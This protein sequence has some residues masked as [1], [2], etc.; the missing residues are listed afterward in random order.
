MTSVD[1][2][3]LRDPVRVA[4][5]ARARRLA[6]AL[7]MPLDALAGLA[8]RLLG[9]PMGL[10]TFVGADEEHVAGAY[11]LPSP[12]PAGRYVVSA[13]GPVSAPDLGDDPLAAQ[14]GVRSYLGV[15]LRDGEHRAVGALAVLD[16]A[17]RDWTAQQQ[18]TLAEIAHLLN[19]VPVDTAPGSERVAGLDSAA[20]LDSVQEAFVAVGPDGS[21][22]AWNRA[23]EELLGWPAA[24]ICGRSLAATVLPHWGEHAVG[25]ALDRL[26]ATPAGPPLERAATVRHRDGHEVPVRLSLSL[27][28]GARGALACAFVTDRSGE[29]SA[30]GDA[31][32]ER[33]FAEALLDSLQVGVLAWDA[34]GQVVRCNRAARE[35]FGLPSGL[36]ATGFLQEAQSR[37][38]HPDGTPVAPGDFGRRA[39]SGT[40]VRDV[41]LVVGYPGTP[42]RYLSVNA[43]PLRGSDG[44]PVGAVAAVCDVT[45]QRRTERFRACEL[46]VARTLAGAADLT[47]AAPALLAAVADALGWPMTEL[48]LVDG[49][50]DSLRLT[51]RHTAPDVDASAIT[52]GPLRR[53]EGVTGT[54]W[55]TGLPVWVPDLRRSP[56]LADPPARARAEAYR[57]AGVRAMLGVPIDDGTTVVGVLS[58][59]ADTSE[60]D[61]PLI[62]GLLAGVAGQLGLFL[63]RQ[64]ADALGGELARTRDDFVALVG[65]DMRTPLTTVAAYTQL[66]LDDPAPRPSMDLE[67]LHGIERNSTRL[68]ALVDGLLDLAALE[69]GHLSLST[70]DVDLTA[71]VATARDGCADVAEAAGVTVRAELAADVRVPGD[72]GRLRQLAARLITHAIGYSPY[73]GEVRVE[74]SVTDGAAQLAVTGTGTLSGS[75]EV[76]QRFSSANTTGVGDTATGVGLAVA[77]I[78]TERHRGTIGIAEHHHSATGTTVTVRLPMH[79]IGSTA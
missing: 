61:Q 31:E 66:L 13:D 60:H 10:V 9:A 5:V 51:A 25:E 63:A 50:S 16:G 36:P 58:G 45:Q 15:P 65:H 67:L 3:I 11:R 47:E 46:D 44:R 53:G 32:R 73:G 27:L 72:A 17:P 48:R 40:E 6:P 78:I 22:A 69:A 21:V 62:T 24:E 70:Q 8:A 34:C 38:Y 79:A 12:Y 20:L 71:A 68:R 56:M 37:L 42:V 19:P 54:V 57:D 30:A 35:L 64:R 14:C 29:V 28:R 76:F 4:A 23:A 41:E 18:A 55:A 77:R 59:F 1:D 26:F 33:G 52:D 2:L 49:V 43:Q 75:D 74:L 39:L 7:P